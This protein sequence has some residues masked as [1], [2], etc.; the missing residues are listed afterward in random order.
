M[1]ESLSP[2]ERCSFL[3]HDVFGYRFNEIA[4]IVG[5]GPAAVRQLASRA[6]QAVQAQRP[7]RTVSADEQ[8]QVVKAFLKAT[9][10]GDIVALMEV[11]D[12]DASYRGDG[13]G[14]LPAPRTPLHGAERVARAMTAMAIHYADQ[15]QVRLA[16]VNGLPGLV[17]ERGTELTVVSFTLDGGRITVIDAIRNP[18][19]PA[20]LR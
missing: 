2:A 4:D 13:G 20:H 1:L 9:S 8:L 14:I 16:D 11:L 15:F 18:D 7:R 12:P 10:G 6:R 3:L 19:K 5:R 17:I